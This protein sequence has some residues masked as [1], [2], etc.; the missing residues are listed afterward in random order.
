MKILLL[1]LTLLASISSFAFTEGITYNA[2]FKAATGDTLNSRVVISNIKFKGRDIY[3]QTDADREAYAEKLCE[4]FNGVSRSSG[5]FFQ[6]MTTGENN[7]V[8]KSEPL[9][10]PVE[11]TINNP[12]AIIENGT[13]KIRKVTNEIINTVYSTVTC[14]V[15]KKS[16][17]F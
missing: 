7:Q 10:M 9:D 1:S 3:A 14:E 15:E 6:I 13:L 12:M 17:W 8:F 4:T 2:S 5:M 11:I 16:G